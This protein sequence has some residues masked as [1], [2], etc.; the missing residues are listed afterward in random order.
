MNPRDQQHKPKTTI[1]PANPGF[2][3]T[4][5]PIVAWL[6]ED[7]KVVGSITVGDSAGCPLVACPDGTTWQ[8]VE[9]FSQRGGDE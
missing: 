8:L 1:I 3:C 2:T 4:G 7:G 6:I 5:K 9:P